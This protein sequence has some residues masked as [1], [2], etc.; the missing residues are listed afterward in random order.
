MAAALIRHGAARR[1][2]G[3]MVRR[4]QAA[5]A[6]ERGRVRLG[7]RLVHTDEVP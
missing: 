2:G 3:S 5:V 1:L 6:E 4:A 7:P